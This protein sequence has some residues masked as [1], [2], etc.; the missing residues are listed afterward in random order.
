MIKRIELVSDYWRQLQLLLYDQL[1]DRIV[2]LSCSSYDSV[3]LL[4][5]RCVMDSVEIKEYD[6]EPISFYHVLQ[7]PCRTFRFTY[8]PNTELTDSL[9]LERNDSIETIEM[10]VYTEFFDHSNQ[11]RFAEV[12]RILRSINDKL[13]LRL[14]TRFYTYEIDNNDELEDKFQ[15]FL[16]DVRELIDSVAA[17]HLPVESFLIDLGEYPPYDNYNAKVSLSLSFCCNDAFWVLDCSCRALECCFAGDGEFSCSCSLLI[18]FQ[19]FAKRHSEGQFEGRLVGSDDKHVPL[20]LLRRL[21]NRRHQLVDNKKQFKQDIDETERFGKKLLQ[22]HLRLKRA[23]TDNYE[24]AAASGQE[25]EE[26]SY[27]KKIAQKG[28]G[29]SEDVE[30]TTDFD[31]KKMVNNGSP[32]P[33]HRRR[34]F[35]RRAVDRV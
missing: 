33:V 30:A 31:K 20:S 3:A 1:P 23:V 14:E 16:A 6:L 18:F 4:R 21:K 13:K 27:P 11:H 24:L 34:R 26:P 9:P 5:R 19:G 29:A 8:H 12:F 22:E 25:S 32:R 28:F 17:V 35:Q 7:L 2:K 15:T 10:C